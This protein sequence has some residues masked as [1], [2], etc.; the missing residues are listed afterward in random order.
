MATK[1][2]HDLREARIPMDMW[3][4]DLSLVRHRIR[5]K[6]GDVYCVKCW[7]TQEEVRSSF[8]EVKGIGP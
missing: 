2:L 6:P 3:A 7:M 5:L 1:C 4:E 8:N